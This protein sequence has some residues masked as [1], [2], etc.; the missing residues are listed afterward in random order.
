MKPFKLYLFFLFFFFVLINTKGQQTVK[1]S[2]FAINKNLKLPNLLPDATNDEWYSRAISN[3]QQFEYDFYP[4]KEKSNFK[5]ANP[6]NHIG[7][8]IETS[9]Y[10][11]Q[12]IQYSCDEKTW[13]QNFEIKGIGRKKIK[14]LSG[15]NFHVANKQGSIVYNYKD[16]DIEYINN[17]SGLRQ[18]FVIN[19]KPAGNGN[20]KIKVNVSGDLHAKMNASG[21]LI[22]Y[23]NSNIQKLIY[24]DLK[25]WDANHAVLKTTMEYNERNKEIDLIVDDANAVYPILV[26]PLNKSPEWTTSVSGVI[27]TLLS[28]TQLQTALYGYAVAGLGDVNGDGYGDA[29]VTAPGLIDVFSGSGSLASVG[30]VF[31]FY[32]SSSGLSTTPAKTLQPNTA[33]AGALFGLS[34]DAGDVNGD[35]INDIIIGSPLD[36]VDVNLGLLGNYH[37][38]IG[39]VYVYPGGFSSAFNPSNFIT[40]QLNNSFFN[41]LNITNNALFGFSVAATEDLNGDGKKDIVVGSPTYA[42]AS[43]LVTRTGGAFIF[44]S[45]GANTFTTIQSLSVPTFSLL[46]ISIPL[47]NSINGLLFGY[48]VDGAGDYNGDGIPD[49]VVGA[50]AGIDLSSL[51][52]ILTGQILG[53]QAYVYYGNNSGVTTTIGAKLQASV[54][55]LL[56]NAANLFGYKVRGVRNALGTKNGNIVIGAPVGGLIPNAL[57]LTIQTGNVHVFKKKTSS[58]AGV[59][60]SNQVLESPKSTSLLQLLGTL[61]LNVLFGAGID[62]AYDINCDGYPDLV[63]GEPLSS[64]TNLSQLQAN[65]VGGA[66]YVFLGTATG[67]YVS[68]PFYEVSATYGGDFLSLNATALFGFN[69]A[70]VPRIKGFISAPRIL[71]G[72]PSGALDFDNSIINLGSTLGPLFDFTIGNNGL[73]KG[74]MFHLG[75]CSE[76][77]ALP[78]GLIEFNGQKTDKAVQLKWTAVDEQNVSHYEVER[79][80]DGVNFEMKALVFA[81]NGLR[82]DYSLLDKQPLKGA[83]YYRLKIVDNDKHYSYSN[84]INIKFDERSQVN[85]VTIPNPIKNEFRIKLT[86]LEEGN[87]Q[88]ELRNTAGQ[89]QQVKN[90]FVNQEE[91]IEFMTRTANMASGIYWLNIYDKTNTR[92]KVTKIL[93]E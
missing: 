46:G 77:S 80:G 18:N 81:V 61:D 15:S 62:N 4:Q 89:L 64:G 65:A 57:G 68:T 10:S 88:I 22:F 92:I 50:P 29:A 86:G 78:V 8:F 36:K 38:T 16:C 23:D 79:S 21:K 47:I 52:G 72:S 12:N 44:L 7:F 31:V 37:E 27:S 11:V 13:K 60:T 34:I 48:S 74:Y 35:G 3:L 76:P 45:N 93:V 32:G 66:A 39:K 28:Q 5:V 54:S 70:G 53:G 84:V 63:V 40:L 75:Y 43:L 87:Y 85:I 59:V 56:S 67:G 51:T 2:E 25:A 73:G 1:R 19:T 9:S 41:S 58:P 17:E 6:K 91:H 14:A 30:A 71:V 69:V 49:V 90:I 20:L 42:E 83:N 82:N 24:E 55:G 33:V 26:D